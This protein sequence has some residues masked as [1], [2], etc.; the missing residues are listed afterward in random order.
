ML[1]RRPLVAMGAVIAVMA[2]LIVSTPPA[3]AEAANAADFTPGNLISDANFFNGSAMAA[4]AVQTLLQQKRPD[5]TTGYTCLKDYR[6]ATPAMPATEYCAAVPASS[7]LRG[8]DIIARVGAACDISQRVLLVLLEKEQSLVTSSRPS[9]RSYEA[10]TGFACPD[11]AP[12]DPSFGGFFYQVYN[13]ARQFQRYAA[14]PQSYNHRVRTQQVLFHPNAACGS[15]AVRIENQATAGLYNY[16]PYQPNAAALGNLYGT[17]DSCSA[18]GNRNFWRIFTDWFGDPRGGPAGPSVGEL[19]ARATTRGNEAT[20]SG[21]AFDPDTTSPIP[22]H[23]YADAPFPQSRTNVGT[24]VADQQ[25]S[26]I[27]RQT[28]G[29]GNAFGFSGT[30]TVPSG[31]TRLC[32]HAIDQ[33]GDGNTMIGCSTLSPKAGTPLGQFE[34]ADVVGSTATLRGWAHDPDSRSPIR[35]HAYRGGPLGTGR[36]FSAHDADSPRAD[37]QRT[38]ATAGPAHGFDIQVPV[39]AGGDEYCLYAINVEGGDQR[40]LGCRSVE[41]RGGPPSGDFEALERNEAGQVVVSG[42]ALDPD[43]AASSSVRVSVGGRDVGTYTASATR[44]DVARSFPGYGAARGFRVGLDLGEGDHRV[45]VTALDRAGGDAATSLGCRS[46][47]VS[48]ASLLPVADRLAGANRFLT[49]VEVSKDT[50]PSTAPVVYLAS[51]ASFPDGLSAG[52]AAAQAGGPVLLTPSRSVPQEVL[53]EIRRLQPR[54]IV[55]V[56]GTPSVSAAAE[57]QVRRL[58]VAST[59]ERLAGANRFETSRMIADHA[60]G[61]DTDAVFLATGRRFPDALA[62]GPAAAL[63]NGPVL[64]VDGAAA[65]PDAATRAT[66]ASLSPTYIGIAGDGSAVS[67]GIERAVRTKGVT[68]ER[69]AGANRFETAAALGGL[70]DD[71]DRV[72]VASGE[73]FADALPGAA[74]AGAAG[75]PLVLSRSG[76][77]PQETRGRLGGWRPGEVVLLGGTPTLGTGVASYSSCG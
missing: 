11:T 70:F 2:G 38:V 53:A 20:V 55:I 32:A 64:L 14:Y 72:L 73:G 29:G 23:F 19:D 43:T 16:T 10:A 15:S 75:G 51:G 5:C 69:F 3:P 18:Y 58:G 41:P 39:G 33:T 56:G 27:G 36:P 46:I 54:E 57:Q 42:W 8:S 50:F 71:V 74:A 1:R 30:L 12:C 26:G 63:R 68:V 59:V 35:V 22:V 4:P 13:A 6:Q 47:S 77:M 44:E 17:G 25:R 28:P 52:P 48:L 34:G 66:I 61:E 9:A 21:W 49:S 24:L 65:A 37:V 31:T 40:L 7:N 60:F 45:C 67:A 62:A 76:C